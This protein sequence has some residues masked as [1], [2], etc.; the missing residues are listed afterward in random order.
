[1]ILF[2]KKFVLIFSISLLF[3]S[4]TTTRYF[5]TKDVDVVSNS[6]EDDSIHYRTTTRTVRADCSTDG[7]LIAFYTFGMPFVV[8]GCTVRETL[9]VVGYTALN[10]VAG[11]FSAKSENNKMGL[12]LPDSTALNEEYEQMKKDYENSPLGKYDEYRKAGTKAVI[13]DSKI[14][15]EVDWNDES[16]VVSS[17]TDTISVESSVSDSASRISKKASIIGAKV[18]NVTSTIVAVPSWIICFILG[19]LDDK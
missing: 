8:V 11:Y 2:L 6:A 14:I 18:G 15:E 9:K 13:I 10:S 12:I 1:M 3:I 5:S 4:C 16:K 19:S 7:K 17:T